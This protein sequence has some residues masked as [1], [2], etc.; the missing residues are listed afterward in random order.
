MHIFLKYHRWRWIAALMPAIAVLMLTTACGTTHA[1]AR[2]GRPAD[3]RRLAPGELVRFR[4]PGR[5]Q[6]VGIYYVG[7]NEC[8]H[9]SA[10]RGVMIS[11]LDAHYWRRSFWT[12]RRVLD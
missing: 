1:L 6:P 7:R 5:K 12:A 10:N 3:R 11:R 2:L 8:V 9:A 4:P